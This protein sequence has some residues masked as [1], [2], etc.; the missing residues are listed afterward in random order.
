M[1]QSFYLSQYSFSKFSKVHFIYSENFCLNFLFR[2][3]RIRR[4]HRHLFEST[5]LFFNECSLKNSNVNTTNIDQCLQ[6]H[7]VLLTKHCNIK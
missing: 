4:G 5:N 2:V 1:K 3:Q 7:F 6:A